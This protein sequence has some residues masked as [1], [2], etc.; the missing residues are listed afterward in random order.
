MTAG[1]H[2][3]TWDGRDGSG[4]AVSSGVYI[5]RLVVGKQVASGRML[6]LK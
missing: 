4:D 6:L 3:L 1:A 5:T 2:S